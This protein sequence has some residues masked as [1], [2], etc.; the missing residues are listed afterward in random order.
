MR[1]LLVQPDQNHTIGLQQ[2]ARVEPLGLEMLAGALVDAHDVALLD[3]RVRPG[4]L[5]HVLDDVRPD[6]VGITST[7]T[8][9]LPR[10]LE[11]ARTVKAH[12]PR[13]FVVVGG[14]HVSLRPADASDPAIDAIVVGEGETTLRELVDCLASG[15]DPTRVPG[16]VLNTPDGQVTTPL[17]PLLRDLDA[18]PHPARMLTV[19]WR[20]HYYAALAHPLAS[21]ESA[22]GC[23]YR[24]NFCSVWRFYGGRIRFKSAARVVDELASLAEDTV[25]FTDDNFL[26]SPRRAG[27]VA[28]L[29]T[30]R[31]LRKHYNMQARSDTIVRHPELLAAWREVGLTTVVIGFEKPDQAALEGVNKH[32]SVANNE[33]ALEVLRQL[34]IEPVTS[35]IV[36]P[37]ADRAD[38]AALAAY[39]RRLHLRLP[40]FAVLT[41]L[42]GTDLFTAE[43]DRLTAPS[44]ELFDLAHTVL[45]TRLPPEEFYSE[46]AKLWRVAY[47]RWE[48]ALARIVLTLQAAARRSDAVDRA[49]WQAALREIGRFGDPGTYLRAAERAHATAEAQA[50]AA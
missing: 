37:A 36:D 14:H 6:V 7:F 50:Q 26:A 35:F 48:V 49:T 42:P 27:Q 32:N 13:T 11:I 17:R 33:A 15:G 3:L 23:P 34:G 46:L 30:K 8:I 19:P 44:Y 12:D 38:F 20:R 29:V 16:L 25:L 45:P 43:K 1:I 2:L 24:C 31:G 10:T 28:R 18:L 22:R 21:V 4:D 39:V 40:L 5:A 47:P 9:D 41:P